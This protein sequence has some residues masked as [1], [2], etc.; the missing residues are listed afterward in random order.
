M[1]LR[2]RVHECVHA[3]VCDVYP[4]GPAAAGSRLSSHLAP[5][6][7]GHRGLCLGNVCEG[8]ASLRGCTFSL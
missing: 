8:C 5:V 2:A 3:G 7:V 1:G 6:P 4:A